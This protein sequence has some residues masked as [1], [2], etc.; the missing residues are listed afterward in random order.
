MA[1]HSP[2]QPAQSTPTPRR[3]PGPERASRKDFLAVGAIV[4]VLVVVLAASWWG[5]DA[6]RVEHTQASTLSAPAA[7]ETAPTKL[8]ELWRGTSPQTVAP[9]LLSGGVLTAEDDVLSMHDLLS[10]EV[11]WTYDRGLPLC[12]V[13]FSNERIVAVYRGPKG[14]GDVVSLAAGTGEYAHTRSALAED[15][16]T[17]LRSNDSTGIVSPHR[18]ELWR[19]DLVRTTEVGRQETQVKK[20]EQR[21]ADCPFT[22]ALTRTELLATTQQCEGEDK[23]LLRLLKT[24]PE[25]SDV[26]EDLHTFYMPR[27]GQL[28][29][30]AQHHAAVYAPTGAGRDGKPQLIV[31]SDSGEVS[32][33]PMPAAPVLADPPQD[34]PVLPVTADLPHN[35][36]WW[37]GN[38]VV[39][40]HPTSLAPEFTVRGALGAG[41]NMADRLLVPVEDGI[42]VF[43]TEHKKAERTLPVRRDGLAAGA[44]VHL[45]VSGGFVVE[46]RGD[47]LVVL[48]S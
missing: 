14:C 24:K 47:E 21:Y 3:W 7:A 30:I 42:R 19:S 38:S 1:P 41:A 28:V 4:L 11:A 33:H 29:A 27:D 46:Q 23:M 31:A 17:A 37:T 18:V 43:D 44:P 48:G 20:E 12:D 6:R 15:S 26:P 16:A 34:G 10:G 5:S 25:R 32:H 36:T 45:R 8:R 35:M 2:T 22:S 9:I 13:T 39:G 40:F